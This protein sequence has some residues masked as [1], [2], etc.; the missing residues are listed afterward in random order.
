MPIERV[1]PDYSSVPPPPPGVSYKDYHP[2][3]YWD[4]CGKWDEGQPPMSKDIDIVN[5]LMVCS[6]VLCFIGFFIY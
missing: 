6:F 5:I 1:S 2:K 3:G 4:E